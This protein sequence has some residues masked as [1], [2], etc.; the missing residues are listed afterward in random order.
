MSCSMR[1]EIGWT[2]M[3]IDSNNFS[4]SHYLGIGDPTRGHI[5]LQMS[6]MMTMMMGRASKWSPMLLGEGLGLSDPDVYIEWEREVELVFDCHNYSEEKKVK[7][8]VV[9]FTDYAIVWWDQL[10][11]SRRRNRELP[12]NNWEDMKVVMR[13]RFVPSHY[14]R[15][16]HLKLQS[17]KQGSMT[18]EDYHKEMEIALIRANI[19]GDREATMARF[20]LPYGC[21][22]ICGLNR[23][24]ANIVELHHYVELDDVVHMAIKVERQLKKGVRSSS[25]YEAASSSP[26]KQKWGSS[27]PIEKAISKSKGETNVARTQSS[28]KDKG[29]SS[30]QPQRNRDIK[31]FRCLGS[32]HIASQC[33]NKRTMI[34][35][36]NGEIETEEEDEGNEST[37]SVEDTSDVELAVDGRALVVLRALHMQ[38]KGNDD[39]LQ[40]ENI[41]Y[42]LC[43]VKDRVCGLI[44]DGGS[45]VNVASKLM[46]DKLGLPTLKHPK[47][48]RLQWLNNSGEMKVTKQVLVSFTIGRYTDEVLCDVV[49]MQA[50]HLLLGRPWQFDRRTTHDGYKN[51]Y[52]FSKDGRNI[53]L[54]PLTPRQVFEEQLQIKRISR[55]SFPRICH[56]GYHQKEESSIRLISFRELPFQT[57]PVYRSSAEETK[58]LQRQVEEL[59]TKGHVRES[60]SPYVVP[61]LLVPKKDR[62]WRMCVNCR[63]VNKI[64]IDLKSGYHQIRIKEGDEWKITF[65]TKQGLYECKSLH[66]HIDHLKCV[67]EALRHE[68]LFAKLKKCSFCVDRVV[69]LG[70]VVSSRGVEVDEEK[71][72]AIKEWPTPSIITEAQEKAF[73]TLK[74]KLSSAPLLLLPDFS[75]AFEIEYD[76]S[77]IGIGVVLMQENR[78]ITYFS[79]KLNGATLNYSTYDKELYALVR[80]LE[81]WQHYLWSKEFIIHTDHE[82]LKHLKGQ[83][84]LSRRHA[85][86]I[87]FIE[88][89]PYV[90]Q[91]KQGKENVV[92]DDLSRR[93]TLISTLGSKFLG[94]E[95]LKELYVNDADFADIFKACEKGAFDKFYM[96]DGYL[97]RENRLCIPQSSM[98]ELLVKESHGDG[99]MGHFGAVKTLDILKEHFFWPHMKRDVERICIRCIACKK[100]KSKGDGRLHGVPRTTVSDRDAKFL[101]HFWRVLWG[102]LGAKLLFSTT[103]HPQTDGQPEVVNR[104][105]GNLLRSTIGKNLK[106]WEDCIRFIEFV[107]NR[108]THSSTKYSPFEIVYGFNPLTPL[109]LIPLPMDEIASLEGQAKA[110]LVKRIHDKARQHMLRRNE[111]ISTRA[112]KGQKPITFQPGDWV[113]V[114]FRKERFPK[115]RQS[116]LNPRDDGPFQVLEKINDNAYKLDLPGEYQIR[117]RILL[118]KGEGDD[119]TPYQ[120][121]ANETGL[122]VEMYVPNQ[123]EHERDLH[124]PAEPI[125]KAEVK[126]VQCVVQALTSRILEGQAMES[127]SMHHS[128]CHAE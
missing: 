112:N 121:Q 21:Y 84:K 55:M 67:L 62:T 31:C 47:S 127:Q 34:M 56:L 73:N 60:M 101:S 29:N 99:L 122:Q 10:T 46:V 5:L 83:G 27:K 108:V 68:K 78:S 118:R 102:K 65:K 128:R 116:K 58:E 117:G 109:D 93:Y 39:R 50:S 2:G 12:I 4:K 96:H 95:H 120:L 45:C 126:Q 92:A 80:A 87:E 107:Y 23:K 113:W 14:Y 38:A 3:R 94:F 64:T 24:I 79:E 15:D 70:F 71:V 32:G 81:T 104:T 88:M 91:Y 26:W 69:F 40:R 42:T 97:F 6:Q 18:V 114:H 37:P 11:L 103:C 52:S 59:L 33:P 125:T 1:F 89:F 124:V 44:I 9:A 48:Y 30:S 105:L 7:L 82:S 100:A 17:L 8:V 51:H 22:I 35:L 61:V 63:A 57:E 74:E 111:Q 123:E 20:I 66:D 85:R 36:D 54:T 25:K 43:H 72:K 115:R 75:K 13:R 119:T 76:A 16:L 41:F 49:P 90:I 110:D 28:N 98:R 53:T 106:A 19:E 86:W 77:G